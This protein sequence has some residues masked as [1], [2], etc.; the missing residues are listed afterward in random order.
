VKS[1]SYRKL[2]NTVHNGLVAAHAIEGVTAAAFCT[3]KASFIYDN[4]KLSPFMEMNPDAVNEDSKNPYSLRGLI[5]RSIIV[6]TVVNE[7]FRLK[8]VEETDRKSLI[9]SILKKY[10]KHLMQKRKAE[11]NNKIASKL[12][13]SISES[14]LKEIMDAQLRAQME[15]LLSQY[16]QYNKLTGELANL[17]VQQAEC[18]LELSTLSV[19]LFKIDYELFSSVKNV[20]KNIPAKYPNISTRL[21]ANIANHL[22]MLVEQ[23]EN[24][25]N[26][27]PEE[28]EQE[29]QRM[30]SGINDLIQQGNAELQQNPEL[31]KE[32]ESVRD[33]IN[34]VCN[35]KRNGLCSSISQLQERN[36]SLEHDIKAKSKEISDCAD[37]LLEALPAVSANIKE[38]K[39]QGLELPE[40]LLGIADEGR[41]IKDKSGKKTPQ[42]VMAE[43]RMQV[44]GVKKTG[45]SQSQIIQGRLVACDVRPDKAKSI[46]G[47][48]VSAIQDDLKQGKPD[49]E[50]SSIDS[51]LQEALRQNGVTLKENED[52]TSGASLIQISNQ[53]GKSSLVESALDAAGIELSGDEKIAAATSIIDCL[54]DKGGLDASALKDMEMALVEL[55]VDIDLIAD[56]L[57]SLESKLEETQSIENKQ[58]FSSSK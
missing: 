56:F 43:M 26:M 40:G 21:Q 1:D 29:I 51:T 44:Q 10:L 20:L 36:A 55:D 48:V 47:S 11:K 50:P 53:V 27:T 23:Q 49:P 31:L 57:S 16:S 25:E 7:I 9:A 3:A 52:F 4:S 35:G 17:L 19:E 22:R 34:S 46:A 33:N 28:R 12:N 15:L 8:L 45:S 5:T 41:A 18:E 2:F 39:G 42:Q 24:L 14:M 13:Q 32:L 30:Q 58:T 38:C 54:P 37:R 6:V